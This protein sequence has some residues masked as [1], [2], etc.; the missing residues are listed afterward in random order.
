MAHGGSPTLRVV[1]LALLTTAL[2][3]PVGMGG[4]SAGTTTSHR[5]SLK[6]FDERG[7]ISLPTFGAGRGEGQRGGRGAR[8]DGKDETPEPIGPFG[9][10][11]VHVK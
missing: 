2:L 3:L 10:R 6:G 9:V 8:D 11:P 4:R 5:R 1:G 7:D